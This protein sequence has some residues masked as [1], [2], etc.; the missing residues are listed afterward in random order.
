MTAE[1]GEDQSHESYE[2]IKSEWNS[3]DI[4]KGKGNN[5]NEVE[6]EQGWRKAI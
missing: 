5:R 2:Q 3:K 1:K 4:W 6:L